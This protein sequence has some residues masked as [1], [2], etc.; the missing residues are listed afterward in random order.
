MNL[1][2]ILRSLIFISLF[3]LSSIFAERINW[4]YEAL[5]TDEG[6]SNNHVTCLL[7][8]QQGYLWV[9]TNS[10]LNRYYGY[11]F[12][13][14][15][16]QPG[17][18]NCISSS[19]IFDL[20]Q[21]IHNRIWIGTA[22]GLNMFDSATGLFKQFFISDSSEAIPV[23]SVLPLDSTKIFAGT[24][25]GLAR[26]D[27]ETG[28]F[29]LL[30]IPEININFSFFSVVYDSLGA[31]WLGTDIGLYQY[32]L[33]SEK[34]SFIPLPKTIE[35]SSLQNMYYRFPQKDICFTSNNG[36]IVFFN[37]QRNSFKQFSLSPDNGSHSGISAFAQNKDHS[38]LVGFDH[39]P[40]VRVS[41]K[42]D[43]GITASPLSP[44]S[45]LITASTITSILPTSEYIIWVGTRTKGLIKII[46]NYVGFN[47]YKIIPGSA[48]SINANSVQ[49]ISE[50]DSGSF[51]LGTLDGLFRFNQQSGSIRPIP[52]KTTTKS[53][54]FRI[55]SLFTDS[56]GKTWIGTENAGLYFLKNRAQKAHPFFNKGTR[57]PFLK[58]KTIY[59]ITM[60]N[61]KTLW[62]GTNHGLY[63]LNP[64]TGQSRL[65]TKS[66][67][68][69]NSISSNM[70]RALYFDTNNTLWI[71]TL[72]GGLNRFDLKNQKFRY[73]VFNPKNPHSL[74]SNDVLSIGQDSTGTFFIG[75][76]GGGL[77]I[78][79][80]QSGNFS[81]H[82]FLFE[83]SGLSI[84]FIQ[85]DTNK[86]FW[87]GTNIGL[88]RTSISQTHSYLYDKTDGLQSN[89]F[90]I[91]ASYYSKGKYILV[92]GTNGFNCFRKNELIKNPRI[93]NNVITGIE[94]SNKDICS[95]KNTPPNSISFQACLKDDNTLFLAYNEN[96]LRFSFANL[97]FTDPGQNSYLYKMEPVDEKWHFIPEYKPATYN[98]LRPGK[99]TF[100]V[101]GSNNDS[102]WNM[103]SAFINIK[104]Q[105][106]FWQTAWF[107]ILVISILLS[108]LYLIYKLR[109]HSI[110][111]QNETLEKINRHLNSE[112]HKRIK[113]QAD[114]IESERRLSTLIEN[115]PGV[116]YRCKPDSQRTMEFISHACEALTG[117][118]SEAFLKNKFPFYT[119]LIVEEDLPDFWEKINKQ[120]E[121]NAAFELVYRLKRKD[122][123]IIWVWEKGRAIFNGDSIVAYEGFITD[124]TDR[125]QLEQNL[126]QAQKMEA[127]G[128]LASGVAHDFNNI[129]TV[130]R[131]Y[132]ELALLL[133]E[134]THPAAEKVEDILN[135][136]GR[137]EELTRQLLAFSRKNNLSP[138]IFNLN[139]LITEEQKMLSRIL[140]ELIFLET[141]LQAEFAHIRA[142]RSQM[143]QVIMNLAINARDA[144]PDG[145]KLIIRTRNQTHYDS[146]KSETE[147]R[148]IILSITD[149]GEGIPE[150]NLPHIFDPFFTTKEKGKGTGLGLA[151]VYGIIQDSNGQIEAT[152]MSGAG[153]TF[154]IQLPC[155]EPG[156][157][158]SES[159]AKP[160]RI[161][162]N[163]TV[164]LV[165]DQP[166]VR[167]VVKDNL[168]NL[169]YAVVE[170][171]SGNKALEI[172]SNTL[173]EIDLLIT[174][175]I[176]PGMNGTVLAK[177]VQ[178]LFPKIRILFM[179]GYTDNMFGQDG[180]LSPETNFIQKPFTITQLG[181]K[182]KEILSQD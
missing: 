88:I 145:G 26:L 55:Y 160:V 142:D 40:L 171:E 5:T 4:R 91:G 119:S 127:I 60:D 133:L 129:L 168:I 76:D 110:K 132:G 78:F 144:M 104:I 162:G 94:I 43:S 101:R 113:A 57:L 37:I 53:H 8:D 15:R 19:H 139:Q 24:S 42:P 25:K 61:T 182:I 126:H 71:G 151:T 21:G 163:E 58:N 149:S 9:G 114:L 124:I 158:A 134:K 143:Q 97:S 148:Y 102:R 147:S 108:L 103:D 107:K 105:S 82:P 81:I 131:G 86:Y 117:Y 128:L 27:V 46:N 146:S 50:Q 157:K 59:A 121:Q 14:F 169:G 161:K 34:V 115:L 56:Y 6:L 100:L 181:E 31:L 153:T 84:N 69:T 12:D 62:I 180:M 49:A 67:N 99:Y 22:N 172:C 7:R 93:G 138:T 87:L 35:N 175:I 47:H 68:R 111:S 39:H 176:M 156:E 85:K 23:F 29:R 174:D 155:I 116:T 140:G 13:I 41:V 164:L 135:T 83:T 44:S 95:F 152:S 70:I 36:T 38:F 20:K 98:N 1:K 120:T 96:D 170:A 10:G 63:S 136:T 130:I 72:G 165:D 79:N 90:N 33:S 150:E 45:K 123:R 80:P 48:N 89:Q 30:N 154:T 74:S 173:F 3:T 112:I 16:Q 32:Q 73:Y 65:Y 77:N 52:A 118:T 54:S 18:E 92:G 17:H 179:S 66:H 2:L 177:T 125:K 51:I 167:E 109:L 106:A 159:P 137:A 141:D 166:E 178:E 11:G 122:T 64:S 75:T 28:H